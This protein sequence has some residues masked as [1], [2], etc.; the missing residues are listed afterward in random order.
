MQQGAS[1]NVIQSSVFSGNLRDG[2][3][4]HDSGTNNNA[5][6]SDPCGTN[7]QGSAAVPN[8]ANGVEISAGSQ[9]TTFEAI[10]LSGNALAGL[11]IHDPGT[12]K[13]NVRDCFIGVDGTASPG[14][15]VIPNG[16][17][18]VVTNGASGNAFGFNEVSGNIGGGMLIQG[19]SGNLLQG[20]F[21]GT[22]YPGTA[23]L[24]NGN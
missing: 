21:F 4:I 24:P 11:Y 23:A 6:H 15:T 19:S 14:N 12:S 17:G 10:T 18:V 2:I 7:G 1:S 13:A 20:N 8:R 3:Y 16:I 22:N 9:G 5:L